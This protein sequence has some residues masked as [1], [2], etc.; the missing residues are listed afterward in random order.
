MDKTDGQFKDMFD[1]GVPLEKIALSWQEL[2]DHCEK[3]PE[4]V[5]TEGLLF[6]LLHVDGKFFV[7]EVY[8]D[9]DGRPRVIVSK[10]SSDYVW[11]AGYGHRVLVATGS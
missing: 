5:R 1:F 3:H 9:S 8:R 10:L 2:L 11:F 7:A 4:D 6:A